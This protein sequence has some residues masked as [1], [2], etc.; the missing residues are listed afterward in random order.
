MDIKAYYML[1]QQSK[2]VFEKKGL[3]LNREADY[4]QF[5]TS[6][7]VASFNNTP[8]IKRWARKED[9]DITPHSS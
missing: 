6:S 4:R 3:K 8:S 2:R 9:L 7:I 1:I 5:E